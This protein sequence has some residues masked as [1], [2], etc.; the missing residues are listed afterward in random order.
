MGSTKIHTSILLTLLLSLVFIRQHALAAND[1]LMEDYQI[2][3][4]TVPDPLVVGKEA[5]IILKILRSKN[6]LPVKY[7]QVY[8]DIENNFRAEKSNDSD[9]KNLSEYKAAIEADEFGNYELRTNFKKEGAYNIK[10][11]I[12][13]LGGKTFNEPLTAGFIV[14][15]KAPVSSGFK[16]LFFLSTVLIT[17]IIGLY[18]I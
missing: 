16:L 11:A 8:L 10:V 14:R 12:K 17:T 15:V 4:F 18:L 13:G 1:A 2:Q 6:L 3:I 9:F 7:G 5:T